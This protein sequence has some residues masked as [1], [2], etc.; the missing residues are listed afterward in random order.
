M[1]GVAGVVMVVVVVGVAGMVVVVV[2]GVVVVVVAVAVVAGLYMAVCSCT[3]VSKLK[4]RWCSAVGQSML[5][6]KPPALEV[7]QKRTPPPPRPP[8]GTPWCRPQCAPRVPCCPQPS[9]AW[10]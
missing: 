1:V 4:L 6:H 2:V 7:D 8:T 10:P 9:Q 5:R 3:H